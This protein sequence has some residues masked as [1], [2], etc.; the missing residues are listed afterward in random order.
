MFCINTNLTLYGSRRF[1]V[2]THEWFVISSDQLLCGH[3]IKSPQCGFCIDDQLLSERNRLLC[4]C[5][6]GKSGGENNPPLPLPYL[7]DYSWFLK[8]YNNTFEAS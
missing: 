4:N 5:L 7:T 1:V 3:S 2:L 8:L 6:R